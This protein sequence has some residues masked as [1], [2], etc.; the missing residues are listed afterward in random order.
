LL[1]LNT[2]LRKEDSRAPGLALLSS[3]LFEAEEDEE[4]AKK[5]S[6]SLPKKIK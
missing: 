2:P 3:E 1:P 4:V 5:S 6:I